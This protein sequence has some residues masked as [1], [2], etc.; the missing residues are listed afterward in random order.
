M[1][2]AWI[3]IKNI[4]SELK[5]QWSVLLQSKKSAIFRA[6]TTI[7]RTENLRS[8]LKITEHRLKLIKISENY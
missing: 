2:I 7:I 4:V 8:L 1:H 6:E 5:E 3:L